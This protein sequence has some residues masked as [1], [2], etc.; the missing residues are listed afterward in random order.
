[1]EKKSILVFLML[2][3]AV[4][5]MAQTPAF[6]TGDY[7]KALWMTTRF[8]GAQRMGKNCNN[9]LLWDYQGNNL[10]SEYLHGDSYIKDADGG[11]DLSG[12][13]FDCGDFVLFGQTFYYSEYTL[14]LAY[15]EFAKGH[16][17]YYSQDYR[18]YT[19]K[20]RY[21]W[22]DS[23]SG[24]GIPDI[25]DE[26]KWATDFT[27]KAV[28]DANTFYYQKG[29]GDADHQSWMTS[30]SKS[31][32]KNTSEG[33]ETNGSRPVLKAS[34][35]VTDMA[36][37]AG[38]SLAVM[39]RV[40]A[41]IDPAY[42][43]KCK[44]KAIVAYKFVKN[45][46]K[47]TTGAGF[48]YQAKDNTAPDETILYAEL[49]R[50]TGEAKYKT[51]MENAAS[52]W[53]EYSWDHGWVYS[54][55]KSHDV[56]AY[57]LAT[58][59]NQYQQAGK[60][61]L[62]GLMNNYK[63]KAVDNRFDRGDYSWGYLRYIANQ[64]FVAALENKAN[65]NTANDPY[66]YATIDYILGAN[67]GNFSYI[68]GFGS[69][70]PTKPHHRNIFRNDDNNMYGLSP[71]TSS[72]PYSELGYLAGGTNDGTYQDNVD[73]YWCAEGGI[74]YN[75]GLVGALGY[76]TSKSVVDKEVAKI[77]IIKQPS[78]TIYTIGDEL[79]VAGGQLKITYTDNSIVY[80]DMAPSMVS[81]FSSAKPADKLTLTVQFGGKTATYTVKVEKRPS[82]MVISATPKTEYIRGE[83]LSLTGG[84]IKYLYN[85][86]TFDELPITADMAT[87]FS[88]ATVGTKTVTITYKGYQDSYDVVIKAPPVTEIVLSPAPAKK[89]Y[90]VNEP[91]DLTGG[92]I[93]IFYQ[94]GENET[95]EITA[96]M[97]SGFRSD[98]AGKYTITV[99]Y[100]SLSDEYEIT[101]EK[102]P[103][104]LSI[105]KMPKTAYIIADLLDVTGGRIR[106]EYNDG[107][108]DEADLTADM[109]SGFVNSSAG[110]RTLKVT[111]KELSCTYDVIFTKAA[112]TSIVISKLPAK[113]TYA[114]GEA[115]DIAGA[116]LTINYA[117]G[118][119]ESVQL[120]ADMISGYNAEKPGRQ[121]VA[122][123]CMGHKA[124]FDV[125]VE[126][127]PA[128][129]EPEDP[130]P[131]GPEDPVVPEDPEDPDTPVE[132]IQLTPARIYSSGHTIYVEDF[133]GLV[134]VYTIGGSRV[135]SGA[136]V[137]EITMPHP[138]IYIVRAGAMS[139]KVGV[140]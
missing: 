131:A 90:Q 103:T 52:S 85:D 126:P 115:L 37:L 108:F 8:Y 94:G 91:L 38:A 23:K 80:K 11:Y 16:G 102:K 75:A 63:N 120:T 83:N 92:K 22:E 88:S 46:A 54:Y 89:I 57:L 135:F 93:K 86:G 140:R 111:Y 1:M 29:D 35:N 105:T 104:K 24:N 82:G 44:D 64:A 72:Y 73:Q 51:D 130:K 67:N 68:V 125:T 9:W 127:K 139:V 27:L 36:A 45:T 107:T 59:P 74:D 19:S 98:K 84:L 31:A 134:E 78:T 5:G 114:Y 70:F 20:G 97:A 50:L 10:P 53:I 34:G 6:E 77:E 87:G 2:M 18:E 69:K 137:R 61:A 95:I 7:Q 79:S 133:D 65:N 81:G 99:K 25:L 117:N 58:I 118:D 55:A 30:P 124:T 122:V 109:V 100:G 17:D 26:C 129:P 28:R 49:F 33:G 71:V 110:T 121:T 66:I 39:A 12:G 3:L 132:D 4:S 56:A 41:D 60:N 119:Q 15:S 136:C 138:G 13:W 106:Y 96:D 76:I 112:V 48:F 113:T 101:V 123:S 32:T 128:D 14:L 62:S 42:A 47:G 40:Y 43:E 116:E 21:K